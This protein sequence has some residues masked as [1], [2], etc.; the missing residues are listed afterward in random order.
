MYRAGLYGK[1]SGRSGSDNILTE[2][3]DL[4]GGKLQLYTDRHHPYRDDLCLEFA[5]RHQ[6]NRQRGSRD[7]TKHTQ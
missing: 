1:R 5:G 7:R 3:I 2:H 4:Y 6:Y